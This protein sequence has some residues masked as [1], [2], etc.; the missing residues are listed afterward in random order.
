MDDYKDILHLF[1]ARFPLGQRLAIEDRCKELFGKDQSKRPEKAILIAT[2]VA[3]QSLDVNF[4]LLITDL[5]PI[6]S[7][8]IRMVREEVDVYV[9]WAKPA[10]PNDGKISTPR[11]WLTS[12]REPG[13]SDR[14]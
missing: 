7:K 5:A 11:A 3:E 9:T 13:C 12:S 8:S 6:D 4:D 10:D 1:H 14:P 2:Q